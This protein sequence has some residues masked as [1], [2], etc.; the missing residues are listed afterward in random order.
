MPYSP[1]AINLFILIAALVVISAGLY[2]GKRK[3]DARTQKIS[4]AILIVLGAVA[5]LSYVSFKPFSTQPNNWDIFHYYIGSKYFPEIGY[6]RLYACVARA[7]AESDD[8]AVTHAAKRRTIRDLETNELVPARSYFFDENYCKER[9]SAP[10]WESFKKD[11]AYFRNNLKSLWDLAQLDHGFNPSPAWILPGG[12]AS[13][14]IPLSDTAVA[15]LVLIDVILLAACVICLAWAFGLPVAAFA[16]IASLTSGGIDWSWVGGGMLRLDWLFM[17]VLSVCLMKRKHYL[18][19]GAALGYAASVR[20]F[21]AIFALGPF[22]GLAYALYKQQPDQKMAYLKFFGGMAVSVAALVI[23]VAAVYGTD[24]LRKFADNTRKHSAVIS[25]NN[26]GLRT[27]LTYSPDTAVKK[28]IDTRA[29]ES[30]LYWKWEAA[31][32][33]AKQKIV[34]LYIVIIAAC[35]LLYIPTVIS[36]NAWQ[37]IALG[38]TFIP[39]AWSEMSNYYYMFLILVATFFATQPKVAFPLLGIGIITW[40]GRLYE[41]D[42]SKYFEPAAAR[43]TLHGLGL[44]EIYTLFSATICIGFIIIWWQVSSQDMFWKKFFSIRRK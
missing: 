38:A 24:S 30:H 4:N 7:E 23:A 19:A 29:Q 13:S 18:L 32:T 8:P 41:I 11:V 28:T 31:K 39:F 21:P 36:S 5:L 9:F 22:I 26:V 43:A 14:L 20:V 25:T 3:G 33:E 44:D 35:L 12:L 6:T 2:L 10:R 34:P 40:T 27:V 15:G 37:A 17:A 16:V 1:A 42:I